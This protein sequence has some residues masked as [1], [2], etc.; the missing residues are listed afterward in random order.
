MHK[1]HS[2]ATVERQLPATQEQVEIE[3]DNS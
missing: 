1:L 2:Y 3:V